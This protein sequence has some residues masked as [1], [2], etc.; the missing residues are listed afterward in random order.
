MTIRIVCENETGYDP[1]TGTFAY[2]DHTFTCDDSL[3]AKVTRC[4]KCQNS[5]RVGTS[6]R[7]VWADTGQP[8]ADPNAV[9]QH[10]RKLAERNSGYGGQSQ[11][12]K[13]NS[14][15]QGT[16]TA[17]G[18]T[19]NG[20][21]ASNPA[22][23]AG[24]DS[25]RSTPADSRA[26]G[27]PVE[28]KVKPSTSGPLPTQ[29]RGERPTPIRCYNCGTLLV[30]AQPKC[31]ACLADLTPPAGIGS[32][33][34]KLRNPVG[35]NRWVVAT[36]FSGVKPLFLAIALHV[37][38]AMFVGVIYGLTMMTSPQYAWAGIS[39]A[40]GLISL[41][42]AYVAYAC[43]RACSNLSYS[44]RW[45]QRGFWLLVLYF[46]RKRNW[47]Y[48]PADEENKRSILDLRG[49]NI[50][51]NTL[52]QQEQLTNSEVIDVSGCPLT[53]RGTKP[54][55][56]LRSLRCLVLVGTAISKTEVA[57]LQKSLPNCW[58]WH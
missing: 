43:H 42:Y 23:G 54:L 48:E 30:E 58:I 51:D 40:A 25:S 34:F 2:C 26:N 8:V 52:V 13:A 21:T 45:W 49:K 3:L 50:N 47:S 10:A 11:N 29:P 12:G 39:I 27:P 19:N 1:T 46:A 56:Y 18:K 7:H 4:P 16:S 5:I 57:R 37:T 20:P 15:G 17:N 55:H 35:F 22:V 6:H 44:L 9:K 14:N 31:P 36:A 33:A 41:L 24:K 32:T 28:K 38:V 53:D